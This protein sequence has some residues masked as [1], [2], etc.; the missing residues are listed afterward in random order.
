VAQWLAALTAGQARAIAWT[1][2]RCRI[3]GPGID[4]GG[5]WCAQASVTLKKPLARDDRP[6]IEVFFE[7]PV[8]GRPGPAYAFRGA[9]RAADGQ[10]MSRFRQDFEADWT[11]RFPAPPGAVVDCPAGE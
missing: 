1:G 8:R 2:G 9:M 10:D 5:R 4:S 6:M 7:A 11:S 3:V